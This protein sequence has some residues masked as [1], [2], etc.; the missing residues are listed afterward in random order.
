MI[1]KDTSRQ[2]LQEFIFHMT[3]EFMNEILLGLHP[4]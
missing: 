2:I 1:M 4:K 3:L